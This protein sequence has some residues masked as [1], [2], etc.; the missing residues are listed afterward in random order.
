MLLAQDTCRSATSHQVLMLTCPAEQR[1]VLCESRQVA[2]RGW[3]KVRSSCIGAAASR[4]ATS[5][6]CE[7]GDG[8]EQ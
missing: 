6:L 5:V 8:P 4:V 2:W 7:E 3:G 1:A